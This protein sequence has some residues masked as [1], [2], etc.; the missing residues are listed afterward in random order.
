MSLAIAIALN[1]IAAGGLLG[2]LAYVMTRP[3][4]L[5]PHTA[6]DARVIELPVVRARAD[7]V[8]RA[9]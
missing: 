1:S 2:G 6:Q 5:T 4:R 9:A 8:R 7:E 3:A